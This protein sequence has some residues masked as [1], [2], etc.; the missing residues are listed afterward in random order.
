MIIRS[1]SR[2]SV[3]VRDAF[4]NTSQIPQPGLAGGSWSNAGRFVTADDAVGLPPVFAAIRLLAETIGSIEWAVRSGVG[5][6]EVED[7]PNSWQWGLFRTE[8]NAEQSPFDFFNWAITSLQQGNAYFLKT[9][10]RGR[11]VELLPLMPANVVPRFKGGQM[12]YRVFIGG[13][14][15]T[16]TREDILHVPGIIW[17]HPFI[18]V[19]PIEM[20]RNSLGASLAAEEFG[21]R[22]FQNDGQPGGLIEVKAALKREQRQELMAGWNERHQGVANSHN[23]G[24]LTNGGTYKPLGVTL[25]DALYVEAMGWGVKQAARVFR[26]PAGL[27]EGDDASEKPSTA[28]PEVEDARFLK[29]SLQ[30]WITRVAQAFYKDDDLFP[31]KSLMPVA[32]TETLTRA[33]VMSRNQAYL[34][35]R[36]A[37]W[38]SA[39][40]IRSKEGLP[41]V[42]GGDELQ[43]TP[44][45]G[46]PNPDKAPTPPEE[47]S[48][49]GHGSR[50]AALA[51]L[52]ALEED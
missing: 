22:F 15:K 48:R 17:K 45:G 43:L 25:S 32:L 34:W 27:L 33:D 10:A 18:G 40:E 11:V 36:Q 21:G 9:K 1:A 44:V 6:T 41:P 29:Y 39:N 46:A 38:M 4:S 7:K 19:S 30:Q 23:T 28:H 16:L 8:P 50:P 12:T 26:V 2:V 37:G 42:A 14:V 49:N 35:A 31:D 20:H 13:A 3:E 5:T 24:L 52:A 47:A 51:A